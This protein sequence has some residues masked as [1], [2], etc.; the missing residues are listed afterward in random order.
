MFLVVLCYACEPAY[1]LHKRRPTRAHLHKIP[2]K[3]HR[4]LDGCFVWHNATK[5]HK[6]KPHIFLL[7]LFA[8]IIF[9][10]NIQ[11][12]KTKSYELCCWIRCCCSS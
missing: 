1:L 5:H 9:A 2:I 4:H 8:R 3:S 11:K 7:L 10:L 12:S 6:N